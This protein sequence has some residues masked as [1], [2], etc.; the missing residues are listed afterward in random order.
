[1]MVRVSR[2][3]G[4]P[5]ATQR[6]AFGGSSGKTL[7]PKSAPKPGSLSEQNA[8]QRSTPGLARTVYGKP[9]AQQGDAR[10]TC[11]LHHS[12]VTSCKGLVSFPVAP[13]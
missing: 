13:Y 5:T 7:L 3:E 8:I 4:C 11:F 6:K 10:G 2:N 1:M 9:E 12:L